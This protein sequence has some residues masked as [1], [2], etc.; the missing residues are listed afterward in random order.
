[1]AGLHEK[2]QCEVCRQHRWM[3][4]TNLYIYDVSTLPNAI[5]IL[6][7]DYPPPR[8]RRN[9]HM[10]NMLWTTASQG[11]GTHSHPSPLC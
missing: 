7:T 11:H 3:D 9:T 5:R 10:E 8:A 6:I 4:N 1:M 2:A